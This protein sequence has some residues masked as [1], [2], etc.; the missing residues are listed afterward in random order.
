MIV[1]LSMIFSISSYEGGVRRD[2]RNGEKEKKKKK[3]KTSKKTLLSLFV[4]EKH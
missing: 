4:T 1:L 3:K 2:E